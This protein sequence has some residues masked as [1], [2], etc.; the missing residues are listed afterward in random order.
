MIHL[1]S[2]VMQLPC[3]PAIAIAMKIYADSL[4]AIKD[5]HICLLFCRIRPFRLVIEAAPD[6]S[7]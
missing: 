2:I 5:I 7:H 1:E 4:Y 6:K 3:H